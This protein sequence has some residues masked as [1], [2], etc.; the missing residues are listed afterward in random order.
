LFFGTTALADGGSCL[1]IYNS[2]TT[3]LLIFDRIGGREEGKTGAFRISTD[4]ELFCISTMV[5]LFL[6]SSCTYVFGKRLAL[7]VGE[8]CDRTSDQDDLGMEIW[9]LVGAESVLTAS[10]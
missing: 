4:M 6:V 1:T 10:D 8:R 3:Y 9:H 5:E 7:G 2:R